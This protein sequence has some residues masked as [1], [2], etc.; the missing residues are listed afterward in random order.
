MAWRFH[1]FFLI[2]IEGKRRRSEFKVV[3]IVLAKSGSTKPRVA[4]HHLAF[5]CALFT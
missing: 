4:S 3:Q 5:V 2:L 1:L